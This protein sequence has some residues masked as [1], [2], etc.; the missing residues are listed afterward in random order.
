M[1]SEQSSV[2]AVLG[3]TKRIKLRE[4][5]QQDRQEENKG[6]PTFIF[7]ELVHCSPCLFTLLKGC[8]MQKMLHYV[9]KKVVDHTLTFN[10]TV[11]TQS[12]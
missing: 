12:L 4:E 1:L 2:K 7:T 10:P 11:L 3:Q 9:V 5:H 8:S 6:F